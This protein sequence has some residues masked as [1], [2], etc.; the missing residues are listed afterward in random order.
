MAPELIPALDCPDL[1]S[2]LRLSDALG[3]VTPWRKV[4][5][6]LFT[7]AG[8]AAVEAL[9]ARGLRV[10][11]DLKIYDIPNTAAAAARAAQ[12][13]GVDMLTIHL[14][15]GARMAAAILEAAPHIK[16]IGVTALTSFKAG[17]MPGVR[18]GPAAFG[19][20][21]AGLAFEW[22]LNG[23]VC[24]P[25]EARPIKR[26]CPGLKLVCPGIRP[27]GAPLGDQSRAASPDLAARAGADYLV[28]G[29]PI[30]QASDPAAAARA[31]LEQAGAA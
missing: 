17:E 29:R 23:V 2:A 13:L 9:K 7:A 12:A 18:K 31:I 14:Q 8:P 11:L 22:G 25:L 20:L 6:E 24:S 30:A 15:G 4:G 5:L 1:A 16:I 28:A 27:K 19:E 26:R 3:S 21:L 10:F